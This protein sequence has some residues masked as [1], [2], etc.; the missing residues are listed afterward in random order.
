MAW[1]RLFASTMSL[2]NLSCLRQLVKPLCWILCLMQGLIR[3]HPL[4]MVIPCQPPMRL[5]LQ[6]KQGSRI[7]ECCCGGTLWLQM[8]G[9]SFLVVCVLPNGRFLIS[10]NHPLFCCSVLLDNVCLKKFSG[11]VVSVMIP[12]R[13]LMCSMNFVWLM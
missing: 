12:V 13:G 5:I 2:E 7:V 3:P 6:Q 9:C 10:S 1:S 4:L 11:C 8:H